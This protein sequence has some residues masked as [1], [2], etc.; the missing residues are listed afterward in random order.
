MP[1][2]WLHSPCLLSGARKACSIQ[3]NYTV[4][5]LFTLLLVIKYVLFHFCVL[6][7]TPWKN[8]CFTWIHCHYPLMWFQNLCNTPFQNNNHYG[9]F[10][11][12]MATSPT[13]LIIGC[14]TINTE[15]KMFLTACCYARHPFHHL[16]TFS[17]TLLCQ[18]LFLLPT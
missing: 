9:Y 12:C 6:C 15:S 16:S 18:H 5:E 13:L 17:T 7:H 4:Y 1:P 2:L 8:V 3:H 10:R 14:Y 11:N